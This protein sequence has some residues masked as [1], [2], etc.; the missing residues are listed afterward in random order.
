MPNPAYG[1]QA[2][3]A[4]T[5]CAGV[6]WPEGER[7][8]PA[9]WTR[10]V[11]AATDQVRRYARTLPDDQE[12]PDRWGVATVL[13]V[14]ERWGAAKRDGDVIAGDSYAIRAKDLTATVRGLLRPKRG[15]GGVG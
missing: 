10:M 15:R 12:I 8:S 13:H 9:S 2:W 7:M 3:A 6:A 5:D 14:R 4:Q 1:A 11:A